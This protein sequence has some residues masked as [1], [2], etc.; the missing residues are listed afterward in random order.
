MQPTASAADQ[1]L[2]KSIND[3]CWMISSHV[4]YSSTHKP[5]QHQQ[6]PLKQE[7]K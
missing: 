5:R 4:T 3:N 7:Q 2:I 1:M 6:L